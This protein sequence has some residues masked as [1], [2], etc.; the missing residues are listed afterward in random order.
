MFTETDAGKISSLSSMAENFANELMGMHRDWS[1][2]SSAPTPR[3]S[4]MFDEE[5]KGEKSFDVCH[6]GEMRFANSDHANHS[7]TSIAEVDKKL[8]EGGSGEWEP[9]QVAGEHS[10]DRMEHFPGM[11]EAPSDV[12]RFTDDGGF[13]SGSWGSLMSLFSRRSEAPSA[14]PTDDDGDDICENIQKM[15]ILMEAGFPPFWGM[16]YGMPWWGMLGYNQPCGTYPMHEPGLPVTQLKP[17]EGCPHADDDEVECPMKKAGFCTDDGEGC[18]CNKEFDGKLMV[19]VDENEQCSQDEE[20]VKEECAEEGEGDRAD[21][22]AGSDVSEADSN[23]TQSTMN[24]LMSKL[25]KCGDDTATNADDI[26][27]VASTVKPDILA[28]VKAKLA[29]YEAEISIATPHRDA[30]LECFMNGTFKGKE[31]EKKMEA[32]ESAIKAV[33]SAKDAYRAELGKLTVDINDG[34][35]ISSIDDLIAAAKAAAL[36]AL[37]QPCGTS[38]ILKQLEVDF[39]NLVESLPFEEFDALKEFMNKS[40]RK[41][42]ENQ[43]DM[44]EVGEDGDFANANNNSDEKEKKGN[45]LCYPFCEYTCQKPQKSKKK[46]KKNRNQMIKELTRSMLMGPKKIIPGSTQADAGGFKMRRKPKF[47]VPEPI[48]ISNKGQDGNFGR[49]RCLYP[50][51]PQENQSNPTLRFASNCDGRKDFRE[52][53]GMHQL[54]AL[55]PLIERI[56]NGGKAKPVTP[57]ELYEVVNACDIKPRD[58]NIK[59]ATKLCNEWG[60][61]R[62]NTVDEILFAIRNPSIYL[63]MVSRGSLA[64][65]LPSQIRNW[66]NQNLKALKK[67]ETTQFQTPRKVYDFPKPSKG[68]PS[69]ER[70]AAS[71]D[72]SSLGDGHFYLAKESASSASYQPS[73]TLPRIRRSLKNAEGCKAEEKL[74]PITETISPPPTQLDISSHLSVK[75]TTR[76]RSRRL[77]PAE[78]LQQKLDCLQLLK[79]HDLTDRSKAQASRR[80]RNRLEGKERDVSQ[81][82]E[83]KTIVVRNQPTP[84]AKK[85]S[86]LTDESA[87]QA[88]RRNRNRIGKEARDVSKTPET[89]LGNRPTP[90]VKRFSGA[91]RPNPPSEYEMELPVKTMASYEKSGGFKRSLIL[92]PLK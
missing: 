13:G 74:Q 79:T 5:D 70:L 65:E 85:F 81:I 24:R 57:A 18:I 1:G 90:P 40:S 68:A 76:R 55:F 31:Y 43:G 37:P 42:V 80:K 92:K 28:A 53:V 47:E 59:T 61:E 54:K 22:V 78:R 84:P 6:S 27:S 4:V 35:G 33:K 62:Q 75:E 14:A 52:I 21:S 49:K 44:A 2:G 83:S 15:Q 12:Q 10:P 73:T 8:Q 11:D 91:G 71:E 66:E 72:T 26:T 56:G 63:D 58:F 48:M 86:E 32:Y 89:F 77:T 64:N 29:L 39:A 25:K 46:C 60:K 67:T 17:G 50:N 7:Q 41:K 82:S 3:N 23:E 45:G 34:K 87:I 19:Y 69:V 36:A 38:D 51:Q 16:G 88:L 9:M 20:M 30:L